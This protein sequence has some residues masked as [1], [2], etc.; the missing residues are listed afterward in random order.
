M[1]VILCVKKSIC[2]QY[3]FLDFFCILAG[4]PQSQGGISVP[5]KPATEAGLVLHALR[6]R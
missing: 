2:L 3:G 6:R 5:D 1:A 4:G